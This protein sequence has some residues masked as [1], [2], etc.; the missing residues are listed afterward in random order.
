M[1]YPTAGEIRDLPFD[2]LLHFHNE[3]AE[4]QTAVQHTIHNRIRARMDK[5]SLESLNYVDPETAKKFSKLQD[6]L[7]DMFKEGG[8][9]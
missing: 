6:Q 2:E 3:L 4:P 8:I 1:E 9:I 5:L 7:S